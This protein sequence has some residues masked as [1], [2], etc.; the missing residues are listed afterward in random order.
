MTEMKATMREIAES[1]RQHGP[2][3]YGFAHMGARCVHHY[4]REQTGE[5]L[6]MR[7]EAD[8]LNHA[9]AAP[10]Y[11]REIDGVLFAVDGSG[12]VLGSQISVNADFS[13][14]DVQTVTVKLAHQGFWK[15]E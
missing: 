6:V 9:R 8:D 11:L 2:A 12:K 14:G 4:K 15:G 1:I 3:T 10:V 5:S 7:I 13:I